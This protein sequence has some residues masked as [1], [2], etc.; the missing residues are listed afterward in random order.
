[1]KNNRDCDKE[2]A[3]VINIKK[4]QNNRDNKTPVVMLSAVMGAIGTSLVNRQLASAQLNQVD[5]KT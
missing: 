3:K 4:V 5:D 2:A 1:M